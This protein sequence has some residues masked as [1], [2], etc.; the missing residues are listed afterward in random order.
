MCRDRFG[1]N[2]EPFSMTPDP[3][4]LYL[5]MQHRE[6]LAGLAFAVMNEKGFVVLTGEAG[7]G[8]TTLLGSVLQ[9][10]PGR[11]HSSLIFNP[12]LTPAEFLEMAMLGWGIEDVPQSKAQRLQLLRQM[13]LQ[14]QAKGKIVVLVVDEAH[15]LSSE[16]LEEIRLLGNFEHAEHKLLQI[17]LAGQSELGDLLARENLRQFKQRIAVRLKIAPLSVSEVEEYIRFR[18]TKAGGEEPPFSPGVYAGIARWSRGIP[19]VINAICD[20]VLTMAIA[21]GAACVGEEHVLEACQDLDLVSRATDPVVPPP[22]IAVA[23]PPPMVES[24]PVKPAHH[25]MVPAASLP[26]PAS[27]SAGMPLKT[28]QRYEPAIT[29]KSFWARCAQKLGLAN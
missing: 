15:T 23:P 8:K 3:G 5:T 28:L 12:T 20:N 10:L 29:H 18:W 19:R 13:L 6:A 21:D 17:I 9:H 27:T 4:M 14:A 22:A 26:G 7:T 24:V 11:V 16:V 2:K 1:L 25:L